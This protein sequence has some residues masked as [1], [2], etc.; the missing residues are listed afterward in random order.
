MNS[1]II[2]LK[3]LVV[4]ALA[5][6]LFAM[7]ISISGP[8]KASGAPADDIAAVYKAKCVMCHAADGSGNTPAGKKMGARDLRSEEVQ[9]MS[10]EELY[11]V[12]AK[13]K[14]K[15]PGY[16]KSLGADKCKAFVAYVRELA[17]KD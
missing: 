6:P 15:M 8:S 4:V 13:G 10:D 12:I 1:S 14:D 3:K 16:E 11:A 9:N 17:K 7:A 5:I 2:R